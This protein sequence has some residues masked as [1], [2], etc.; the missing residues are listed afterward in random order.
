M[1]CGH[2]D[3]ARMQLVPGSVLSTLLGSRSSTVFLFLPMTSGCHVRASHRRPYLTVRRR[4]RRR[5]I[6]NT[7]P[8]TKPT[9]PSIRQTLQRQSRKRWR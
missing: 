6:P 9:R 8:F 3:V 5:T 1:W 7:R 2:R 4:R